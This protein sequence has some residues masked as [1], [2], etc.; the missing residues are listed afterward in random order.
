MAEWWKGD[1]FESDW[2]G[3]PWFG[4]SEGGTG[5]VTFE[6]CEL[7]GS[8]SVSSATPEVQSGG[9]LPRVRIVYRKQSKRRPRA[10]FGDGEF[11][12]PGVAILG[13]GYIDNSEVW[14]AEDDEESMIAFLCYG[15]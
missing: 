9:D 11:T 14:I 15:R 4:G 10:I 6:V 1:W 12:S 5:L 8:G 3:D 13:A 2:D 7:S